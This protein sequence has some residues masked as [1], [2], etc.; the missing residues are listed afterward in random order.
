MPFFC[1]GNSREN[2]DVVIGPLTVLLQRENISSGI[3]RTGYLQVLWSEKHTQTWF[4]SEF[5]ELFKSE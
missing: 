5:Y 3:F 4:E 2:E 1:F